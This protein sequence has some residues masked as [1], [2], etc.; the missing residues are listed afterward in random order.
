LSSISMDFITN[1]P[2]F[3]SYTPFWWWWII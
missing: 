2:L 1:L 3:N